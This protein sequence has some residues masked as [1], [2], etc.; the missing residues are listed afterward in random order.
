M[1][2]GRL[3]VWYG[4]DKLTPVEWNRFVNKAESLGYGRC[5]TPKQGGLSRC[6]LA[7][8]YCHRP[9]KSVSAAR[10]PTFMPVMPLGFRQ[11]F[12]TL[13]AI[14]GNRFV[15]GLGVSHVPMVE[16]LRGHTYKTA[17]TMREYLGKI[18]AESQ[19]QRELADRARGTG[20]PH[21][22]AFR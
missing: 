14:S 10:L 13:S 7:A 16:N 19:G 17:S 4:A 22:G 11:G 21:A 1:D 6:P 15:L 8:F 20:P 3:G 2:L 5:G 18:Y 12:Q 9:G